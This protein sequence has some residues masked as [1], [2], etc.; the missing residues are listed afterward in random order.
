MTVNRLYTT[1]LFLTVTEA[2]NKSNLQITY[3]K[4]INVQLWKTL[5]CIITTVINIYNL[6]KSVNKKKVTA[7]LWLYIFTFTSLYGYYEHH[8]EICIWRLPNLMRNT[9]QLLLLNLYLVHDLLSALNSHVKSH[10][11]IWLNGVLLIKKHL[12]TIFV[13]K[14]SSMVIENIRKH[15]VS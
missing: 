6:P 5:N 13:F 11:Y 8:N 3:W 4:T 14:K 1:S 7:Y 10:T 9:A 15:L 12:K 2:K